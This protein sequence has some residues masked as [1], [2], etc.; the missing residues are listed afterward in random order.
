MYRYI[1]VHMCIVVLSFG[2]S[3]DPCSLAWLA[4]WF[5]LLAISLHYQLYAYLMFASLLPDICLLCL[6]P[7]SCDLSSLPVICLLCLFRCETVYECVYI[8]ICI[9][10]YVY[11]YIYIYIYTYIYIYIYDLYYL[12][13]GLSPSQWISHW[14]P[15]PSGWLIG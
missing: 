13:Q 2:C 5:A 12:F 8:Y 3:P 15:G 9:D 7:R 10:L 4:P 1:C 11:I 14:W 6:L